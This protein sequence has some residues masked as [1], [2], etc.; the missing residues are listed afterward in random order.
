MEVM[1]NGAYSNQMIRQ[2]LQNY[3]Y[4]D[5]KER[6]FLNYLTEG[7]VERAITLDYIIDSF[8]KTKTRKM[9][10]LIRN[11]IRMGAFQICYMDA[12]PDSAACNEAVKLADKRGFYNLKGFVNGVLRNIARNKTKLSFPQESANAKEWTKYASVKY[13][14][15][16]WLVEHFVNELGRENAKKAMEYF[17]LHKKTTIR[18]NLHQNTVEELKEALEQEGVTVTPASY[19]KSALY[20]ENY[21]YLEGLASFQKGRFQVQDESSMLIGLVAAPDKE[22]Y[23]IDVCAAPGGK[24]THLAEQLSGNGKVSARD[25]VP[26]KVSLIEE[27][28]RRLQLEHIET[29]VQDASE[30]VPED[31]GKADIVIADLPCSGLGVIGRKA[32]IKYKTTKEDIE[33][34]SKIQRQILKTVISYVKPG[35]TL[36]YSTCTIA[37]EENLQNVKWMMENSNLKPESLD[38]YLPK[39]LRCETSAKG[40]LQLIPGVQDTDG[41]FLARL[42]NKE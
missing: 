9:K 11:I 25:L 24:S 31:I 4:L 34:L 22:D 18:C 26:F 8:S 39:D 28:I 7:V 19:V 10:P 37:K 27:N 20:I 36:I 21:N 16:E 14:M 12:I 13:S 23:I 30:C 5:K 38:P 17:L 29:R 2:V 6:A 40:Y 35:G 42:V 32:D 33:E 41:F 1:E 15:P 3:Q